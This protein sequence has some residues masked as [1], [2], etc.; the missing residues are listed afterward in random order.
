MTTLKRINGQH[1]VTVNRE[2]HFFNSFREALE[3]IF[4]RN[5]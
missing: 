3:F 1:I 4:N 2:E 5:G